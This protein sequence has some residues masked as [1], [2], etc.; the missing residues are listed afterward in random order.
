MVVK[1]LERLRRFGEVLPLGFAP[2]WPEFCTLIWTPFS[3]C[4]RDRCRRTEFE[5]GRQ[6]NGSEVRDM[7]CMGEAENERMVPG[8]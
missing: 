1:R 3:E 2:F 8:I 6:N 5:A 7:G 4:W